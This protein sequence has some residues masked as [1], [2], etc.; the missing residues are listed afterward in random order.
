MVHIK[1]S[2]G[3]GVVSKPPISRK[4]GRLPIAKSVSKL[5]NELSEM[6]FAINESKKLLDLQED[7]DSE[8]ALIVPK[9]VWERAAKV[10]S[11]YS[12]WIWENRGIVL[13]T[14]SI[15]AIADGSIDIMWNSPKARLLLNIR[16]NQTISEGHYYGDTYNG[17]NKF[18][19]VLGDLNEVQEF[20]AYWLTDFI[21]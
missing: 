1:E 3:F 16:N 7:W 13:L 2:K 18:K 21:K 8:G 11:M 10:L 19:G 14:P 15:D 17:E 6:A 9:F 20:F 4:Q 12:K 5:P